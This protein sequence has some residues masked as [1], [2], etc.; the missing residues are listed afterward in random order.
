VIV[1]IV[2]ITTVLTGVGMASTPGSEGLLI[3]GGGILFDGR[4]P[5]VLSSDELEDEFA[6]EGLVSAP[7]RLVEMA[8]DV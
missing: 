6:P 7:R 8:D 1:V 3:M 5:A 4:R 2:V